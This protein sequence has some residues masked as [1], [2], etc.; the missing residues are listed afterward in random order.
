MDWDLTHVDKDGN[1]HMVDI[2]QKQ[3]TERIAAAHAVVKMSKQTL[4][5]IESG[6]V[7]KGNVFAAAKIAGIMAA[8]RTSELIPLCHNI[9]LTNI[10][11]EFKIDR[12]QSCVQILSTVK[13]FG[14]TGAEMEALTAV[15]VA[16]LTIYDMCKAIDK[17]MVIEQ[18]YLVEKS[19]GKSGAWKRK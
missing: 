13:C 6:N 5:A 18:I 1:L 8:K 11:L 4:D 15:S 2:T 16:A 17:E 7:K 14:K 12:E 19:G 3:D 9:N 10:E